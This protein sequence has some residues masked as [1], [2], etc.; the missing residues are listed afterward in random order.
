MEHSSWGMGS[1]HCLEF[2]GDNSIVGQHHCLK[3]NV[4]RSGEPVEVTEERGQGRALAG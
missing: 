2:G 3:S 1:D 4:S